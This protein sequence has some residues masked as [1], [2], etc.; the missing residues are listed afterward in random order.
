MLS[1]FRSRKIFLGN[2]PR[3]L[4]PR[5]LQDDFAK[6]GTIT[7]CHLKTNPDGTIRGFGFIEFRETKEANV[8]LSHFRKNANMYKNAKITVEPARNKKA[9]LYIGNI[10]K[11]LTP[12][13]LEKDFEKFGKLWC[14]QIQATPQG[15]S[16]GFGYLHFEDETSAHA[17]LRE[18]GD[19]PYYRGRRIKLQPA[20]TKKGDSDEEMKEHLVNAEKAAR[21][22]EK[23]RRSKSA[24]PNR[25]PNRRPS[26]IPVKICPIKTD[27]VLK[28]V[29]NRKGKGPSASTIV[30]KASGK[31]A[32]PT[33]FTHQI[34][35]APPTAREKAASRKGK[36][37]N[38][39]LGLKNKSLLKR[40][41]KTPTRANLEQRVTVRPTPNRR[42]T[43]SPKTPD[44][45]TKAAP[46]YP[47][48]YDRAERLT[49]TRRSS[50]RRKSDRTTKN[51]KNEPQT[52]SSRKCDSNLTEN[53]KAAD[54]E[55]PFEFD[56]LQSS[57]AS[58]EFD[59]SLDGRYSS[60]PG[61]TFGSKLVSSATTAYPNSP[62]DA[63]TNASFEG[64]SSGSLNESYE[65]FTDDAQSWPAVFRDVEE[66]YVDN[67]PRTNYERPLSESN[68]LASKFSE[69]MFNT[70]APM[71]NGF[72]PNHFNPANRNQIPHFQQNEHEKPSE[73]NRLFEEMNPFD[74]KFHTED[75]FVDTPLNRKFNNVNIH[76]PH[77]TNKRP[78][79]QPFLSSSS[80]R[81][82]Q[83]K[84]NALANK[85]WSP[86]NFSLYPQ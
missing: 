24:N 75:A 78:L 44:R 12:K 39:P 18:Y 37:N 31:S 33:A 19:D 74:K 26:G 86:W 42:K 35:V 22:S 2:L 17:A 68:R 46:G 72:S 9:R 4:T 50:E 81:T 15:R 49:T 38:P 23:P 79:E 14:C 57:P 53:A 52:N 55:E 84:I 66:N 62:F 21:K 48:K 40:N 47:E 8:V 83:P 59:Q 32:A 29:N 5:D 71:L 82:I 6:F 61:K 63:S 67:E 73:N 34:R 58:S 85:T 70:R 45:R 7:A 36:E 13:Q 65:P 30:R 56:Y 25:K 80:P 51:T 43:R 16:K 11:N 77:F 3:H 20:K 1:G 10:P 28:S 64:Q 69:Q 27:K 76:Q 54:V 60:S 41:P